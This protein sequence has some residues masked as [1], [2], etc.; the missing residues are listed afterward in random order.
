MSLNNKLTKILII[1]FGSQFTQLIAR[2]VREFGVF[3]EIISHKKIKINQIINNNIGGIILSGGPL[4]VYEN[5]KFKFDKK[6]LSLKI[7]VLGICF[8]HQILS[9]EL[10]GR[11]KKS[12][13][14]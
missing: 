1:D 8:G 12:K 2:R 9:K 5:D 7:P 14:I 3:S 10:G 6:I 4:N 11:V 13:K